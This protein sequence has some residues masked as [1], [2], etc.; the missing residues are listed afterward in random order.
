MIAHGTVL[1]IASLC[2]QLQEGTG[3]VRQSGAPTGAVQETVVPTY[4][5]SLRRELPRQTITLPSGERVDIGAHENWKPICTG[6]GAGTMT[7]DE[8]ERSALVHNLLIRRPGHVIDTTPTTT[9]E[10]IGSFNVVFVL[11]GSIP[12]AA[13][14]AFAACESYIESFF[15]DPMTITVNVSFQVLSPGVLGSTGSSSGYV[16]YSPARAMIVADMDLGVVDDTIQAFLPSGTTC[17][18]R[19]TSGSTITNENRVFFNFAAYKAVDGVVSGTDASM[20]L[21]SSFA[22]D[23]DPSNGITTGQYS[24]QDIIIHETGHAMGFTSGVDFRFRDMDVL[25]LFRFQRTDGSSDNN[26]DTTAEFQVRPRRCSFNAPNDDHNSDLISAEYR[27]SDGNPYQASHFRE[28]TPNI[29]LMDPALAAGQTF[30]P[31]FYSTADLAM[32]DAIGYDY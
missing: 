10:K 21:N 18:V 24:F 17:P 4:V 2:L 28:Q 30:Y 29:G 14:A 26:P 19:Y 3:A 22:F 12:P 15:S 6:S 9:R 31:A 23:Y 20:T 8:L 1:A 27:M 13:P 5:P 25:D 32:F 11:S 16:S 7:R